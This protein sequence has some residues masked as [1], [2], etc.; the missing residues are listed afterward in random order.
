M[1]G[2]IVAG[3][4]CAAIYAA[5]GGAFAQQP[6]AESGSGAVPAGGIPVGPL[7]AYPGVDFAYGHDDNLFLRPTDRK[8]SNHTLLSP[9]V[10]I[11]GKPTPHTFDVT[12]R[13]DDGRYPSSRADNFTNYALTGNAG[14]VFSAR[15]GLKLRAEQRWGIDPR[16]STQAGVSDTPDEYTNT[17][18]EG[19]FSYGAPGAQGRIEVDAGWFQREYQNN[20]TTTDDFDRDTSQLGGT[21]YWRVAPKTELLFNAK[22]RKIDYVVGGVTDQD[23]TEQ[24]FTVGAKW[25]ATALTQ[26]TAKFGRMTKNFSSAGRQDVGSAST[27]DVGVRW[28]PL[29][30]SVFDLSS[31]K[32]TNESTGVGDSVLTKLYGVTWT[33]AWSS[34]FRS[35]VLA[36]RN[37]SKFLGAATSRADETDSLGFK[38][39]YEFRRWLRL[40][41]DYTHSSRDSNDPLSKYKRNLILFS[42][43]ATL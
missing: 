18:L 23:S 4:A 8:S 30:Y 33:H 39:S 2:R 15:A 25:E 20:R 14:L 31:S 28:S 35:V 43:G 42:V 10:K 13:I 1:K 22:F 37:D 9:Y 3:L 16:G 38:L 26:G 29:T 40:G 17:G 41:A 21:F 7:I 34:R 19:V 24:A 5:A 32:S 27:W 6:A 36:N 12:F 11:E